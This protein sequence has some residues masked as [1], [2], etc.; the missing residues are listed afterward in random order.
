MVA[1]DSHRGAVRCVKIKPTFSSQ[2]IVVLT[3]YINVFFHVWCLNFPQ[4]KGKKWTWK[5]KWNEFFIFKL[6]A[7][8][9]NWLRR[10]NSRQLILFHIAI[11]GFNEDFIGRLTSWC[12]CVFL[13]LGF[14]ALFHFYLH[15][16]PNKARVN[17]RASN[18]FD[19]FYIFHLLKIISNS[20]SL[21]STIVSALRSL[22]Y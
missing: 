8:T 6:V 5:W 17:T 19:R 21:T 11:S 10:H 22:L 2:Q 14:F 9:L 12:R 15:H 7:F 16:L 13:V 20:Y 1:S 4:L 18:M 3:R